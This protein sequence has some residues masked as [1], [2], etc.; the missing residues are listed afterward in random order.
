MFGGKMG[1]PKAA[2][3]GQELAVD[4][5]LEGDIS[6]VETAVDAYLADQCEDR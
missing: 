5:A 2:P 1:N 4:A 3:P 6:G